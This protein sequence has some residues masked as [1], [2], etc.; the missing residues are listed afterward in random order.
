MKN[1][2]YHVS[3]AENVHISRIKGETGT[4]STAASDFEIEDFVSHSTDT[5]ALHSEVHPGHGKCT[6]AQLT[7]I[8]LFIDIQG[9]RDPRDYGRRRDD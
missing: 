6:A 5:D 3:H 1:T 9:P 8:C 2:L 4:N 7:E